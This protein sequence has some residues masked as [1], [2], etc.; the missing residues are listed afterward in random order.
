MFDSFQ[1]SD[2]SYFLILALIPGIVETAK[3][4]G[5][6]ASGNRPLLLSLILGFFFVGF[7]EAITLGL[8]PEAVLPWVRV[9][10]MA[11]AGALSVSG[12]YDLVKKFTG[13]Q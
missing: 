13:G 5:W 8:V 1:F 6:I 10:V 12:S 2:L 11:A 3:K 4:W 7:A 9:V